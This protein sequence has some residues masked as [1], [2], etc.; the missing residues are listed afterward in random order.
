MALLKRSD[1]NMTTTFGERLR[2]LRTAEKL[3]MD[4][5][6]KE[7]GTSSSRISDW[8]N[9]GGDPSSVF[10]V[11]LAEKFGVTLEWLLTGEGPKHKNTEPP[12]VLDT[13]VWNN[14]FSGQKRELNYQNDESNNRRRTMIISHSQGSG[15]TATT[16]FFNNPLYSALSALDKE[17]I[18]LLTPLIK[19]LAQNK[20]PREFTQQM[21]RG[22]RIAG[23]IITGDRENG[24]EDEAE[25]FVEI[26]ILGQA[27]AGVPISVFRL[28]DGYIKVPEQ[29][30]NCFSVRV[31]GDSMVGAGIKDGGYVIVRQQNAVDNGD[32]ALVMIGG[33][34]EEE[35]TI[36][37]FKKDCNKIHLISENDRYQPLIYGANDGVHILGKIVEWFSPE[38]AESRM[39]Q[40]I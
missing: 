8:E 19:R 39:S 2:E 25:T 20:T 13:N 27:A 22:T 31:R 17:D 1:V 24:F 18:E 26:P 3:S 6:A 34:D 11:R 5:L 35:V 9:K 37:R 7:I 38:E 10:V 23:Q 14:I 36:K 33:A 29:Y 32:I 12:V 4:A 15:K 30:K 21:G 40:K 16:L 28:I